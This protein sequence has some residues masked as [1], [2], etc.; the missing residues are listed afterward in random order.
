MAE[1]R[2]S[3]PTL[4]LGGGAALSSF[5]L[6]QVEEEVRRH[7]PEVQRAEAVHL[8]LL[9]PPAPLAVAEHSVLTAILGDVAPLPDWPAEETFL[10]MPRVGTVSPW[11]SKAGAILRCCGL[12]GFGRLERGC[13]WRLFPAPAPESAAAAA[14]CLHDRMV[15]EA[16]REWQ[17]LGR[18]FHAAAPAPGA[19]I[20]LV[21]EGRAALEQADAALGLA[22]SEE[23]Q[24]YLVQSFQQLGRDP[25][26]AELMMF[27][28]INSEHCRHKIFNAAWMA[29]GREEPR[30]LFGMI[31]STSEGVPGILSAYEDNAAVI[32]G[33]A[34]E[35][36]EPDAA[37]AVYR[38]RS[39]RAH[40][41]LKVETHNHPTAIAP[42]PGAGTGIGGEIRDEAAV[43]RGARFGAGLSGFAVSH[44]RLPD[45]PRPWEGSEHRPAHIASPLQIMLQGPIGGAAFSNEFGR[46]SLCGCFRTFEKDMQK[47][48]ARTGIR[49]YGYHKP[50][51]IAGGLGTVRPEHISPVPVPLGAPLV[52]LG[53]PALPIGLGGGASSSR[54]S[55]AGSEELDFA[56]V[57]RQN[58]EMQRRC[59]EVIDACCRL[60][61]N[62]PIALLH[63]VGAGGL[64]NALPELVRETGRGGRIELRSIPSDA[65]GMSP[66]ELW[67]NEAQERFVLV[68]RPGTE[69]T[70][71]ALCERER[72]PWAVVGSLTDGDRLLVT[73]QTLENSAVDLP[74]SLLFGD[75]P[76]MQRQVQRLSPVPTELEIPAISALKE[77]AEVLLSFPA[78][79]AKNFLITIADRTVGGRV[80]R[81]QMAGPWQVPV[82]DAAVTCADFSGYAGEAMAMGE[83]T[84]L[85]VQDAAASARIALGEALTNIAGAPIGDLSAVKLSANWMAAAGTGEEDARLLEAVR[86]VSMELCPAL[87][88]AI[89]V[90][91]DSLSMRTA[92]RDDAGAHEVIAPL[93]LVVSAF[94]PVTDV[95]KSLT[96][97]LRTDVGATCLLLV[98]LGG[99]K[100]RLGG[101]SFLQANA[102]TATLPV[103]DVNDPLL[104]KN[105]FAAVQRCSEEGRLLAYHD[106]SDGG[107]FACVLEM[108]FAA[109]TGAVIDL[110]GEQPVPALFSEE[111][112]AVMQLPKADVGAVSKI[113]E[114]AG[115]GACIHLIGHPAEGDA[116]RFRCR[117]DL[118]LQGGRR[119]WQR[120][121]QETSFRLQSLRDNP[122]CAREEYAALEDDK[123][124][125]LSARLSFNPA[126]DITAP[127]IGKGARPRL[128]VLREQGINGQYEMAAAFD[129]AGFECVDVHTSD[130]LAGRVS[131]ADFHGLTVCGGFSFGDVLGAG[132]GWAQAILQ[133]QAAREDFYE[134]FRQQDRFALGVCNGCQMFSE[135]RALIP[136][137]EHWPRFLRNRSEQFEA[138][139]VLTEV[140]EDTDSVLLA[141]M[142]G[143]FMPVPVA[144]G[145]GRVVF[146]S[147]KSR[148]ALTA[149]RGVALRFADS[150][151]SATEAYPANPNGSADGIAGITGAFGRVTLMMPHPERAFRSVQYSWAP[152]D[153]GES[154]PWLRLFRNARDYLK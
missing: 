106:R 150:W 95:R 3:L 13:V 49:R 21:R 52:V 46:P 38:R 1:G 129:R 113:F 36:F 66:A 109:R 19:R 133:N 98:D 73:D 139:L 42:F 125:G 151:G 54:A 7:A 33:S 40:I 47:D 93:S 15:E 136:G 88:V 20:P 44:L 82:A 117:G 53:G 14:A 105:F 62:S 78:V 11:S 103:P 120:L 72:C 80:C 146:E 100:N 122:D 60:G 102:L 16:H 90:G 118:V 86:A 2:L 92:W 134:F 23:E 87:G 43:G 137:S 132:R 68:L 41:S 148:Q 28:Q 141:G 50:I 64:A 57:Q 121:W 32:E 34:V 71:A 116:I 61:E 77:K 81:D 154:A 51:M 24:D 111:L 108:C 115:L 149:A 140:P 84:P 104:L 101:S 10:V 89:P 127:Y 130:L 6:R 5:R 91:K 18:L 147:A 9:C 114:A 74:L 85:A 143:S 45:W 94:A 135:L 39:G 128:A 26:E 83:R 31:Q 119:R 126:E 4:V 22:L 70:F 123:D 12:H 37:D 153:W 25:E 63:D 27:A 8:Y 138:R 131:L 48:P 65:P 107:L 56:S 99:G 67:C 17:S 110:P 30:S 55:G 79:A 29:D 75:V 59:Q 112:G 69:S 97:V 152:S 58:P 35:R 144:H 145:E 142:G 96:P 76:P 124:P